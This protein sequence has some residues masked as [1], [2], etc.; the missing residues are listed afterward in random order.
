VKC[1]LETPTE[2]ATGKKVKN[3]T[4]A[5][6][7]SILSP[8]IGN[9]VLHH[10]LDTWLDS[11][12]KSHF[13]GRATQIRYVDDAVYIFDNRR[14]AERFFEVLP[15]RLARFGLTIHEEK[16]RILPFGHQSAKDAHAV[17]ERLPTFDFLGFTCYWGLARNGEFWRFRVKSRRDRLRVKLKSL[18]KYLRNNLNTRNTFQLLRTVVRV[19]RGWVNYHVVSDNQRSVNGFLRTCKRTIFWWLNRRG[20]RKRMNWE[21]FRV[22]LKQINFPQTYLVR[23]LFRSSKTKSLRPTHGSVVR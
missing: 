15:K 7:G 10:V 2:E 14:D 22:I 23:S 12:S 3:Q 18:R 20:G 13:G 21:R 1:L 16:S 8:I 4:G 17:G 11:V 6:Q 19:I 5:P 9:I